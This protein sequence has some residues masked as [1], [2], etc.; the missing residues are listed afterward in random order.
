[1]KIWQD[2]GWKNGVLFSVWLSGK[3]TLKA[4][5]G[6][7]HIRSCMAQLSAGVVWKSRAW[8][9]PEGGSTYSQEIWNS[10]KVT[11]YWRKS[12]LKS[13]AKGRCYHE[14][15]RRLW[16]VISSLLLRLWRKYENSIQKGQVKTS[17]SLVYMFGVR[18]L[19]GHWFPPV[20]FSWPEF[21]ASSLLQ[22]CLCSSQQVNSWVSG[23]FLFFPP[24]FIRY[25]AHLHF[26]CYT[27][28][29]PTH[30]LPLFGPGVPLYCGIYSLRVQWASLSSDGQLGHLLI[31][32]QLESRAPGYWLVQ[33]VVPPIGLQIPLASWVLSL[34]PPLG[35]LWSI[36]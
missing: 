16:E 12:A 31:H 36:H 10:S 8:R 27:K 15:N 25:L 1:V 29:P 19:F 21:W 2:K 3:A 6:A 20:M 34:A 30:P 22:S 23:N 18:Q 5:I 33:N 7:E 35:A 24:F 26:Q 28:S 11:K 9:C 4:D 14:I 32:M 17:L 13:K